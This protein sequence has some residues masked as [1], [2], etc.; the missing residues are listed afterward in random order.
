MKYEH[1]IKGVLTDFYKT[2]KRSSIKRNHPQPSYTKNELK[3]WLF[4][5]TNFQE[6]YNIWVENNF[7][8]NL[9]P[10]IDRLNDY[11]GYSFNNIQLT[12]WDKNN[13]KGND[14]RLLGLNRKPLREVIQLDCENNLINT[15][16]SIAEASR[17][18]GIKATH[19]GRVC[20]NIRK[21]AG[22]YIWKYNN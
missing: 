3:D 4:E 2:Q 16:F 7:N 13:K 10:S 12:T 1:T 5:N 8:K 9:K 15:Y 6:L 20:R 22:G 17:I 21:S 18:T 19:I 14:S 11:K